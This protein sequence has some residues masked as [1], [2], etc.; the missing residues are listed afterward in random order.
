M[1]GITGISTTFTLPNYHGELFA[2][3]P[4]ETPLLSMT[5]GVGGG[6]QA[7]STEFEW[8]TYDLRPSSIRT[9]TEGANAPTA[10][11]RVRANVK[12]VCQIY[13]ETV[14]TS[15]TKQ[16]ATGQFQTTGVAPFWT[17]DGLGTPGNP[18]PNEHTWQI[19][20]ALKML[21]RDINFAMWH[22]QK[23]VPVDTSTNP[24]MAGLI[25]VLTTNKSFAF[26]GTTASVEVT[27]A[28][29]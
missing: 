4:T 9:R 17:Y 10:E 12:N 22:A 15:Y 27:A 7:T 6:M 23:N 20:Q 14:S 16:A 26:T 11:A 24:Q 19:S 8:Q 21:A 5:G 2:L 1:A 3:T 18:V 13:H 28:T 29:A 25:S